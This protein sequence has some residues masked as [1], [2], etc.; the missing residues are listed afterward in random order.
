LKMLKKYFI[1]ILL[2]TAMCSPA[3]AN[4][5]RRQ[6]DIAGKEIKKSVVAIGQTSKE[7][8]K[9][10]GQYFKEIGKQTGKVVKDIARTFRDTVQK[11]LR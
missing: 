10:I 8:G 1:T 2:M 11:E 9:T 5:S 4:E 6:A 3:F 7:A